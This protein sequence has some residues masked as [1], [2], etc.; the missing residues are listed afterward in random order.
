MEIIAPLNRL[1]GYELNMLLR[2][3]ETQRTEYPERPALQALRAAA[4]VCLGWDRA[5]GDAFSDP[6][7]SALYEALRARVIQ[8]TNSFAPSNRELVDILEELLETIRTN[9]AGSE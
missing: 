2:D 6:M 1:T 4:R 9:E 7:F 8:R 5:R 3:L